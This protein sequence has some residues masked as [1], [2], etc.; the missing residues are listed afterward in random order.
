MSDKS[1]RDEIAI[2]VM[3]IDVSIFSNEMSK[4]H[5]IKTLE[6]WVEQYGDKS[7]REC[8]ALDAYKM[9]DEMLKA[10]KQ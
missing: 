3:K 4:E 8:I 2:E 6:D 7:I 10:R 1:L 9:A 5:R